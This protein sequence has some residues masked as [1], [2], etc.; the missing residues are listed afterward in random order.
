MEHQFYDADY[1]VTLKKLHLYASES[2]IRIATLADSNVLVNTGAFHVATANSTFTIS[3]HPAAIGGGSGFV[4]IRVSGT[5]ADIVLDANTG[6]TDTS[7]LTV[8]TKGILAAFGNPVR[9]AFLRLDD[10]SVNLGKGLMLPGP[11]LGGKITITDNSV[12]LQAGLSKISITPAGIV[13]QCGLPGVETKFELSATSIVESVLSLTKHQMSAAG[14]ILESAGS[15]VKISPVSLELGSPVIQAK[16]DA[17]F[18]TVSLMTTIKANAIASVKGSM[19][20][21]NGP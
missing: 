3:K 20:G 16:A 19:L 2:E 10:N 15:N 5:D 11:T 14:H 6:G 17:F 7:F 18:E 9:P 12:V 1:L 13:I 4:D 21:L 8:N